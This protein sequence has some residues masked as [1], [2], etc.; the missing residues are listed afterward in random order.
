[1][2]LRGS[3]HRA[4]PHAGAYKGA[5]LLPSLLL[6][7]LLASRGTRAAKRRT[8]A[9]LDVEPY[10]RLDPFPFCVT[11]G[12]F[13]SHTG[14]LAGDRFLLYHPGKEREDLSRIEEA[15]HYRQLDLLSRVSVAPTPPAYYASRRHSIL[16][17]LPQAFDTIRLNRSGKKDKLCTSFHLATSHFAFNAVGAYVVREQMPA[18]GGGYMA[19]DAYVPP[20]YLGVLDVPR[21]LEVHVP[22]G[23]FVRIATAMFSR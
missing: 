10:D 6:L 17:S 21:P 7:L 11:L 20:D 15:C 4:S 16:A 14:G 3:Q 1:M 19:M 23:E 2:H 5:R 8:C 18:G 13:T 9:A 12:S 22:D